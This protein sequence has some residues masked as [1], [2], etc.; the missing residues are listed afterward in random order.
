MNQPD[1]LL[2]VSVIGL[3]NMGSSYAHWLAKGE[4]PGARLSSVCDVHA[5]RHA[6]WPT[7]AAWSDPQAMLDAGGL[8]AVIVATPHYSHTDL[9]IAA[10][11]K[12]L[13]VLVDK[14]ISVHKADAERLI[15]AHRNPKQVFSAMFNQRTDGYIEL[16]K[17][18]DIGT[19]RMGD[20]VYLVNQHGEQR[21]D[22]S[23][24]VGFPFFGELILDCLHRTEHAMTQEHAFKAAEI[25][26]LAQQVADAST[27]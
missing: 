16:R 2:R 24:K 22:V 1:C 21:I 13:H 19:E 26:L 3:G 11:N 14:P 12:G 23:G 8:D 4:V 27:L 20:Q 5:P 7:V 18:V 25:S 17:Y 15:A 6:P 9:G 10:L